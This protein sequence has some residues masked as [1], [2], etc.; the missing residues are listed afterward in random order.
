MSPKEVTLANELRDGLD[1]LAV[2]MDAVGE[3]EAAARVRGWLGELDQETAAAVKAVGV[4]TGQYENRTVA[5]L[6][7]LAK[8]RGIEGY[9]TMN[10]DELADALREG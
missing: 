9:S 3:I 2:A 6:K 5:Q 8:D 4:G 1:Q 7:A 10:K